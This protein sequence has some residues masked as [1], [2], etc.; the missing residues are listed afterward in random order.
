MDGREGLTITERSPEVRF[1]RYHPASRTGL[2]LVAARALKKDR[3]QS[4]LGPT[5]HI[6]AE[7]YWRQDVLTCAFALFERNVMAL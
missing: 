5:M 6:K 7:S 2:A 3:A 1:W 4:V